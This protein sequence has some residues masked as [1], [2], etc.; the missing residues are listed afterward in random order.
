MRIALD[1]QLTIGTATGIGE[2]TRGLASALAAEG[3]DVIELS[4]PKLDPWRFDRRVIWD[5]LRLP[6]RTR[7][8]DADVLHCTSGTMPFFRPTDVKTNRAIPIVVTVHDVAWL[9]VQAHAKWYA[10]YYFG[11][12]ALAQY[13][14]ATRI[15]VDS[16]FSRSE[17]SDV[18]TRSELKAHIPP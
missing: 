3:A 7:D 1:A 6:G 12:F 16:E 17:L 9:R 13:R 8:S 14:C 5:Q 10:R 2:Y 4:E 15:V 18:F 11:N